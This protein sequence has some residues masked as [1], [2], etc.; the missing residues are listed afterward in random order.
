[1]LFVPDVLGDGDLLE[2]EVLGATHD[3]LESHVVSGV[4]AMDGMQVHVHSR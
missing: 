1:M 2:A 3:V 4:A